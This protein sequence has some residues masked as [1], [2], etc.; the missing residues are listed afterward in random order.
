[1]I[2]FADKTLGSHRHKARG[3]NEQNGAFWN[4]GRSSLKES[5]HA[6]RKNSAGVNVSY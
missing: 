2:V 4:C 5:V 3:R 1:V 6:S